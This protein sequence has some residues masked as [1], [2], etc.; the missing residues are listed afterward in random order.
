M[1]QDNDAI[2][3]LRRERDNLSST[4]DSLGAGRRLA[5]RDRIAQIDRQL[6]AGVTGT[7]LV[8]VSKRP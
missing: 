8:P 1:E 6:R 5:Q 7:E 4:L 3:K 2:K